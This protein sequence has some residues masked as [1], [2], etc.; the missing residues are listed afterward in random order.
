MKVSVDETHGYKRRGLTCRFTFRLE[1]GATLRT[2]DGEEYSTS[3]HWAYLRW[4]GRDW[5]PV[6][7]HSHR[8]YPPPEE[9]TMDELRL[10]LHEQPVERRALA[11]MGCAR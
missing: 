2:A 5:Q 9:P 1:L 10:A 4:D 3:W 11:A 8:T 7:R 6:E